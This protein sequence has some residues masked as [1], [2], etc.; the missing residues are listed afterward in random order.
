VSK[1]HR[2]TVHT[3]KLE[4]EKILRRASVVVVPSDASLTVHA[5]FRATRA[6]P[7]ASRA[8]TSHISVV[9]GLAKQTSTPFSWRVSRRTCEPVRW[10]FAGTA[11]DDDMRTVRGVPPETSYS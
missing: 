3:K 5:G 6:Y 11:R 4:G 7:S 8:A 10:V 9:P 2:H 1:N